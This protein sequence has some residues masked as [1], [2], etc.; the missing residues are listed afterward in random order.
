MSVLYLCCSRLNMTDMNQDDTLLPPYTVSVHD[1]YP[2]PYKSEYTNQN[3]YPVVPPNPGYPQQPGHQPEQLGYPPTQ[4]G[5]P[6]GPGYPPTQPGYLPTQT[7][8]PPVPGYPPT[9]PGYQPGPPGYQ[10]N[11]MIVQQQPVNNNMVM[12][13]LSCLCG[14]MFIGIAAIVLSCKYIGRLNIFP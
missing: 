3:A 8:Y 10:T 12:S 6:C 4:P 14:C 1:Q 2:P 5:Y 9:Q 7:G 11:M 13:V